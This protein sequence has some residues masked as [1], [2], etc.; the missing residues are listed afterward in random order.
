MRPTC[1]LL[2][3]DGTL[4]DS[5]P[6]VTAAATAAL[7]AVG[8]AV[9][10]EHTLRSFVGPPMYESFRQVAGLDEARALLALRVYRT[11]YAEHGLP[12][13]A[14]FPGI[15][16]TLDAPAAAGLPMAV[17]TSK[18]EDQALRLV[19]HYGLDTRLETVRGVCDRD[20]RT[21]KPLVIRACLDRL[22]QPGVDTSRPLMAGDRSYDVTSAA[23]E[24]VPAVHVLWGYGGPSESE[25]AVAAVTEPAG[26][27]ELLSAATTARVD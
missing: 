23:A 20:G 10:D 18:A 5:A 19:R 14:L 1:L 2:D 13:S 15:P 27:V 6:G 25:G 3:L 24:G 12:D 22:R 17:A 9:P 26:L 4:V 21:T 16:E 11:H 8:A 7:R